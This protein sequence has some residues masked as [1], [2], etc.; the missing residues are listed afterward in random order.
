[1]KDNPTRTSIIQAIADTFGSHP[2]QV[3]LATHKKKISVTII[4]QDF[5][6]PATL[7]HTLDA[8]VEGN[9]Q[10]NFE[11]SMSMSLRQN[12]LNELFHHPEEL[13]HNPVFQGNVRLYI[14]D[15]FA[16]TDFKC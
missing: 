8:I 1:M 11:R 3:N 10:W 6:T 12:L 7:Q 9:V 4:Y 2:R 5:L 13:A 15:K 14:F 16:T